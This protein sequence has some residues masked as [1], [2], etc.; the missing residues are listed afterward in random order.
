MFSHRVSSTLAVQSRLL[1]WLNEQETHHRHVVFEAD[2]AVTS[3]DGWNARA[4]RQADLIVAVAE[5]SQSP[6]AIAAEVKRALG[7]STALTPSLVLLHEATAPHAVK[8]AEWRAALGVKRH[9]HVR[10]GNSNDVDRIARSL[11]HKSVGLVLG[12]GFALGLSHIGVVQAIRDL[13]IPIDYV[14]GTS[15]GA[16]L[17]AACAIDFSREQMMEVMHKGCADSLKGD[18]TLPLVSLLTGKKVM[19]QLG[20][21][22]TGVDIEDF[23]LPFFCISASLVSARM[24]VHEKGDALR[25]V[26]AT[27]RVPA[28]FPP[29]GWDGD[30]LVDGGLV[31]NV[32]NDVMRKRLGPGTL[33]SV[34][35]SA[36]DDFNMPDAFDMHLSGWQLARHRLWPF[37]RKKVPSL[38]KIMFRLIGLGGV[39]QKQK[40]KDYA[41]VYITPP[42]GNYTFR[43]FDHGEEMAQ[44]AYPYA[45]KMLEDWIAK[46]GRPWTSPPPR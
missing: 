28:L 33:I 11:N 24:I 19:G 45:H 40:I 15:M 7:E 38:L 26:L 25:S 37:S 6:Q 36:R 39:A 22:L 4:Y 29:I 41:D 20:A 34:D 8:T 30:I 21:Y 16:I 17:A 14:A 31:N 9:Y 12:G 43:D 5:A 32:P 3:D 2:L 46:N 1:A 44:A 13:S 42:A 23:W 18:F 10:H 35:V 27:C